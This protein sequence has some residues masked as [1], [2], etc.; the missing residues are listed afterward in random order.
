MKQLIFLAF[1]LVSCAP[2]QT[3]Q[4]GERDRAMS[5]LHATRK[6]F[7]DSLAGVTPEQW[8]WKPAPDVWS[9]AEVAEHIAVSEQGL[10]QLVKKVVSDPAP[11]AAAM[12]KVNKAND[13]KIIALVVDRSKKAQAPEFLQPKRRFANVA[14]VVAQF[15]K[16]RDATIEY[17][18]TTQDALR[19]HATPHPLLQMLD[20]Y[21]WVLLI[22]AH[23][24]R[25]TLQLNEVKTKPGFPK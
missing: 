20:A 13:E 3:L 18:Q 5:H 2:A 1:A 16:D 8:A 10:F 24:E 14:E 22:S 17:M 9:I 15:K 6:L 11:D 23:T 7:L 25:H 4:Q 12:A 21:Q 19:A